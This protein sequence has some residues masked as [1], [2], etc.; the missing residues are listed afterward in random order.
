M[1]N[2]FQY[3]KNI[4]K[5]LI[6]PIIFVIGQFL[7]QYIFAVI[8]NV[9]H[10]GNLSDSEFLKYM[11]TN[12]YIEKLSNY[13]DSKV[14]IISLITFVIFIPIFYFRYKKYITK[15]NYKVKNIFEPILF[16]ITISLIFNIVMYGLSNL[17]SFVNF[18]VS[19]LPIIK[20]VICSGICGP[21]LEEL[22]FRGIVY[23]KLKEFNKPMTAI[24]LCSLV[25]ALFHLDLINAI[26]AFGVSFM[27][28]YLYEKYKT[29]KAPMI[30]HI[31]LNTTIILCANLIIKNN[32]IINAS[33]FLVSIIILLILKKFIKYE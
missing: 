25:F 7:I 17:T 1:E 26:Y 16:G 21:I 22:I 11:E 5:V 2:R 20:Q 12:E 27:F 32:I 23:N 10:K 6:W 30:M 19:K 14:L 9:T 8:F 4:I 18:N 3:F 15:N 13:I 28:I 31:S 29:L 24:I 33:L